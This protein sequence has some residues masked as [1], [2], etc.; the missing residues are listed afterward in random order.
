MEILIKYDIIEMHYAEKRQKMPVLEAKK[1]FNKNQIS[2]ARLLRLV[3]VPLCSV[4]WLAV[5]IVLKILC[6]LQFFCL[7]YVI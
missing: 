6:F 4:K 7:T 5:Q 2:S 1:R 3:T